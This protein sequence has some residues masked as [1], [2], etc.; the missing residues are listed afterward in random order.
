MKLMR[1]VGRVIA[2]IALSAAV[3]GATPILTVTGGQVLATDPSQLGRPS[4]NGVPQDW[5]G[6]ELYP[7]AI[8]PSTAYNFTTFSVNVGLGE[9]VQVNMDFWGGLNSF[10]SAYD[11]SYNPLNPATTWLG[12]IGSSGNFFP[13]VPSFFQVRIPVNHTLVL[14]VNNVTPGAINGDAFDLL[15]EGFIDTEYTDIPETTPVPEPATM[16]LGGTGFALMAIRRR[17]AARK[18]A[19]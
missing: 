16:L 1:V 14:V 12:D 17:I 18:T 3:A 5:S 15:V 7:G 10:I 6:T 4:R 13:G 9:F 19:A 2:L 11:T 8:N